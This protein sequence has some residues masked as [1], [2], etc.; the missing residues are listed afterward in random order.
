MCG[1]GGNDSSDSSYHPSC[2]GSRSACRCRSRVRSRDDCHSSCTQNLCAAHHLLHHRLKSHLILRLNCIH[3]FCI[4]SV[5]HQL[6]LF[7]WTF[8]TL[9]HVSHN[10]HNSHFAVCGHITQSRNLVIFMCQNN[11]SKTKDPSEKFEKG[12]RGKAPKHLAKV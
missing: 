2:S 4:V 1:H 3:N 5:L 9:S 7:F 12:L 10:R 8:C 11:Y 6:C